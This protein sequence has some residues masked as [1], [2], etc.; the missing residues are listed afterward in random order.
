MFQKPEIDLKRYYLHPQRTVEFVR[1]QGEVLL[2]ISAA[3]KRPL[4]SVIRCFIP[5]CSME[6]RVDRKIGSDTTQKNNYA[7]VSY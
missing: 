6:V 2:A 7:H 4:S 1:P 5:K 3:N